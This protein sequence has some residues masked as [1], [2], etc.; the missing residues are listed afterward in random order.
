MEH[1][2]AQLFFVH[3]LQD[4]SQRTWQWESDEIPRF[5]L[6]RYVFQSEWRLPCPPKTETPFR[7][8]VDPV[9]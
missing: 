2:V 7:V 3:G 9:F 5:G 1:S 4:H 6:S 8:S